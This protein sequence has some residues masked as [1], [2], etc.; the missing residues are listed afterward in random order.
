M[1]EGIR[2]SRSMGS[3]VTMMES[4]KERIRISANQ[5]IYQFKEFAEKFQMCEYD[6]FQTVIV[7]ELPLEWLMHAVIASFDEELLQRLMVTYGSM[8]QSQDQFVFM[9]KILYADVQEILTTY[10][11]SVV[12]SSQKVKNCVDVVGYQRPEGELIPLFVPLVLTDLLSE[13]RNGKDCE[14]KRELFV[15]K[16]CEANLNKITMGLVLNEAALKKEDKKQAEI[17]EWT[18]KAR[19]FVQ[20]K[21]ATDHA[22]KTRVLD[23]IDILARRIII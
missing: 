10:F 8:V 4:M 12:Y 15:E 22:I 16:L 13:T 17:K 7:R 20:D 14:Q 21:L 11:L 2:S 3:R 18:K 5:F 19:A 9:K 6:E 23:N 1:Q